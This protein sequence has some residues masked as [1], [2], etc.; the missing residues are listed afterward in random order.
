[1][2]PL[3]RT[4][5]RS[6]V[7][8]VLRVALGTTLI[9]A[10][11]ALCAQDVPSVDDQKLELRI[12]GLSQL[13]AR[14]TLLLDQVSAATG[15][16]LGV[17]LYLHFRGIGFRARLNGGEFTEES[18]TTLGD[19]AQG[20]AM[21]RLGSPTFAVEGG[22]ARRG[23]GS[24]RA[25]SVTSM[26]RGGVSVELPIGA[27]GFSARILGGAFFPADDVLETK[28]FD[29]ET[30]LLWFPKRFPTFLML[31]YRHEQFVVTE[32]DV[33]RPEELGSIILGAGFRF[34]R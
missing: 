33:E 27:S 25:S 4:V 23:L 5:H 29:V 8:L 11:L 32:S 14:N 22:Y 24:A 34:T 16:M 30:T 1:M 20:E 13:G 3:A 9:A 18:G 7:A 15:T 10:P 2:K 6:V 21:L 28:G 26:Y 12:G 31:G 19:V 17:D